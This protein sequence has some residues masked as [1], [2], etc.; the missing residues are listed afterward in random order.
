MRDQQIKELVKRRQTLRDDVREAANEALSSVTPQEKAS[1]RYV[2]TPAK[3]MDIQLG[4]FQRD[5][6][7][8]ADMK[9]QPGSRG[10]RP[11]VQRRSR[12]TIN[13][14]TAKTLFDGRRGARQLTH[15]ELEAA[16]GTTVEPPAAVFR[17]SF[18]DDPCRPK[19]GA[20]RCLEKDGG[21]GGNQP[22]PGAG[23]GASAGPSTAAVRF[24]KRKAVDE[25][26]DRVSPPEDPVVLGRSDVSL[27]T[28]L[29][30]GG[31]DDVIRGLVFAPGPA[32][33]PS[34][35][36]FHDL[37]IAFEPVWQEALDERYVDDVEAA[38]NDIVEQGGETALTAIRDAIRNALAN[39]RGRIEGLFEGMRDVSASLVQEI[40]PSVDATM[41]ITN[42]EW[43]AL[44]Q[45]SRNELIKLATD[46]VA[47]RKDLIDAL[48]PSEL[49]DIDISNIADLIRAAR[50]KDSIACQ[51]QLD[52]LRAEA[53]RI[54]A[55]ARRRLI[56]RQAT[57]P[58][59]PTHKV[60]ESLRRRRGTAYPFRFFAASPSSRSVNFGIVVTYRQSWTPVSY[61]V[62]ELVS[63]IPL[64]PREVRKFTTRTNTKVR[65]A[66]QEVENNL[67]M[68]R[69]E[70]EEHTRAEAEIVAR[71]S[72]KTN[73][74]LTSEGTFS[75][76]EGAFGG[77]ATTTS[78][79]TRDAEQQS[80]A[81]KK[82]FREA[83]IK[84]A[85]EFRNERKVEVTT[86]DTT[87]YER[88]E[89]GEIQ[90]PNDEIPVTFLFYKLQRRYRVAEKL[91][92]LRSVV[93]VAQEV[94]P[95]NAIDAVWIIEH[96]WILN[97]VLLDD[98]FRPA[99]GYASTTFVGEEVV[100]REI[101]ESLFRQR[102]L[103]EEL[104][105]EVADRRASAGLRYAALERQLER[106]ARNQ[107]GGGGL[108]GGIGDFVG[109]LD[110]GGQVL[111][112]AVD[113]LT[114][115]G[116]S[117][118][119]AAQTREAAA[120]DAFDRERRE[121]EERAGRLQGARSTLD[122]MERA[123]AE[124][125]AKHLREVTQVERLAS[126]IVQNITHY[127]QAIWAH[128]P[129]D[130]RFLR[131]RDVP[132]PVFERD[133]QRPR[134]WVDRAP[135]TAGV[136]PPVLARSTFG[137]TVGSGVRPPPAQPQQI[138]TRPLSEFADLSQ[139][140]GFLGNYLILPMYASNPITEL[141]MAPYV[142]IAEGEYGL[143]DPD[144]LGNMTLEE[145]S[146]YVCCLRKHL[147]E[148]EA[149][150][151]AGKDQWKR[152]QPA[153]RETLQRLL[154]LSLRNNDEVVV[155]TSS[156]FIEA[157]PGAHS[158]MER[159]KNLH[160][161]IDVKSAQ[162]NVRRTEL[163]N[164]RRASRILA[165]DLEDPDIEARY[166]FDGGPATVVAP[167]PPGGGGAGGGGGN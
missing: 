85:E 4:A 108:F 93:Y 10:D 151:G 157:L 36:D 23:G 27:E 18:V 21:Q 11:V 99:L 86:E 114:G 110:I 26:M 95:P 62:G 160:R 149:S 88:T 138:R 147:D 100:L 89:S 150:G 35:H 117:E 164:I 103:V 122:G 153:L 65:R 12:I 156:L 105:E 148:L 123:Y 31:V 78:A 146:D 60:V 166:V 134:F 43:L 142:S 63:T 38:Y 91:F 73:F 131:L 81:I 116:D 94:P 163:D 154:Q 48:K 66:T 124:R 167:P 3:I 20:E 71:A 133:R 13:E 83:I 80:E 58:W 101:R 115:G 127:M 76:G 98:S 7:K 50:S 107:E 132:V 109:G 102:Q 67:T 70:S 141:M 96:D 72:A 135:V 46:M 84:S 137:V 51:A 161:Q 126:H 90:N 144:P 59:Q 52:V 97:R 34:F 37:Q 61:Q 14:A 33:V 49:E 15:E 106:N 5:V 19:T 45:L 82:E 40:P 47:L 139:P 54:I 44:S 30:S 120:R 79:F 25:L 155:P 75:F 143:T 87:E 42:A 56:E 24:T 68:R 74:S 125:L 112:G 140:L 104:R 55:N 64:A 136:T 1:D 162:A 111:S 53:D 118:A 57:G 28:P 8:L 159:F 119:E 17:Q 22:G 32:D 165:G 121:E 152:I 128:E 130:Q 158:V 29:T 41:M 6:T 77:S 16:L 9:R 145:F 39:A 129:D 113:F 69:R 2:E 92:R